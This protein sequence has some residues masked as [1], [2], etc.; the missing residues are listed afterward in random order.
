MR[1]LVFFI[2]FF[3]AVWS[4][5]QE[6]FGDV[7]VSKTYMFGINLIPS[8][9]GDI[10]HFAEVEVLAEN[11][12]RYKWMTRKQFIMKALGI[13]HSKAN[14]NKVNLF[15]QFEI[16]IDNRYW[17]P[18]NN[19]W[20]LRYQGHPL[21][22]RDVSGWYIP[23][24]IYTIPDSIF[25]KNG[26]VLD[27]ST[28]A[29]RDSLIRAYDK[30]REILSGFGI[31]KFSDYVLGDN[32]FKILKAVQDKAWIE[33]FI[34]RKIPKPVLL[35]INGQAPKYTSETVAGRKREEQVHDPYDDI[36]IRK[37]QRS[38]L[39]QLVKGVKRQKKKKK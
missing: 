2:C 3:A 27:T 5:A 19:L 26:H 20:R 30:Q 36:S 7:T 24:P 13:V 33:N 4:Y 16:D 38:A 17:D 29:R 10:Y 23:N 25:S 1:G 12:Y 6:N 39:D 35:Q 18:I 32:V 21:N 22:P 9:N 14:P 34:S 8:L 28:K 37:V 31:R 11:K 15:E